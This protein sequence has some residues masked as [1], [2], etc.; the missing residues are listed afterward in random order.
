M[1]F[2]LF[3]GSSAYTAPYPKHL[4]LT[5]QP[6]ACPPSLPAWHLSLLSMHMSKP[7]QPLKLCLQSTQP[8]LTPQKHSGVQFRGHFFYSLG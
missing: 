4:L 1:F 2:F 7:S 5:H 8:E 3:S 6:S